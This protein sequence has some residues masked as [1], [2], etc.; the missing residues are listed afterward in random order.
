M[1]KK[2]ALFLNKTNKLQKIYTY[3]LATYKD[4]KFQRLYQNL[5]TK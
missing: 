2:F 1:Q 3:E 4:T 5:S